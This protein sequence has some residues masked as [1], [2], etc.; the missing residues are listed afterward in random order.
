MEDECC[1]VK[2]REPAF[3][4]SF[5]VNAVNLAVNGKT[6]KKFFFVAEADGDLLVLQIDDLIADVDD[7]TERDDIRPVNA[8]KMGGGQLGQNG[9]HG[10]SYQER[11]P[12]L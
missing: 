9:F 6:G 11:L 2:A 1:L 3:N 4:G 5:E 10:H 7:A 12:V 8:N